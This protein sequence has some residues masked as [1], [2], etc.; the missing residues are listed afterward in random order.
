MAEQKKQKMPKGLPRRTRNEKLKAR[1]ARGWASAAEHKTA[2]RDGQA[3]REKDNRA[4]R[5][6]GLPTPWEVARAVRARRRGES[7]KR[8]RAQAPPTGA[9]EP[10]SGRRGKAA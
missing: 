9:G 4:L 6:A 3:K 10:R 2:N 1:R 8:R 7:L 5:A